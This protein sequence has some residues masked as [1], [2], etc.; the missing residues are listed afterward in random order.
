[1]ELGSGELGTCFVVVTEDIQSH[2]TGAGLSPFQN[3]GDQVLSN[4][5]LWATNI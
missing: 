1:M 3:N 4:L 5:L 2:K